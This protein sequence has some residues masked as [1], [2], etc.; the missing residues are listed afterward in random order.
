MDLIYYMLAAV[1][2]FAWLPILIRFHR[3][4]KARNNPISL[5]ICA[6]ILLLMWIATSGIWVFVGQLSSELFTFTVTA[7]SVVIAAYTNLTFF[8][9]NKRF[10]GNRG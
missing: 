2:I 7:G 3:N 5:A 10:G 6:M 4:W 9:A 8:L 1:S